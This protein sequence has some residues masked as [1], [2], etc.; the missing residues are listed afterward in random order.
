MKDTTADKTDKIAISPKINTT[1]NGE[2][3][4]RYTAKY[5]YGAVESYLKKGKT[6]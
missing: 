1:E 2:S 6:R 4:L 3:P 5:I